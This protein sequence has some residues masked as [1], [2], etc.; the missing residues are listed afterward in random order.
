MQRAWF[1]VQI[2][3]DTP[4]QGDQ[5]SLWKKTPKMLPNPFVKNY[6]YVI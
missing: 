2:K 6:M 3:D 5:I 1:L 4:N